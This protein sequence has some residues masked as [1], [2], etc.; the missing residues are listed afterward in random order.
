L[1]KNVKKNIQEKIRKGEEKKYQSEIKVKEDYDKLL[2][3]VAAI[4]LFNKMP[5]QWSVR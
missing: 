5:E 1:D 4:Q 2:A 3:D